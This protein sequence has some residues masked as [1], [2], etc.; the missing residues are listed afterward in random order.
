MS[1]KSTEVKCDACNCNKFWKAKATKDPKPDYPL[2]C[3]YVYL[4]SDCYISDWKIIEP[5]A[6]KN[7][8]LSPLV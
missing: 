3:R 7:M 6:R 2:M 8:G 4:C 1:R 5:K